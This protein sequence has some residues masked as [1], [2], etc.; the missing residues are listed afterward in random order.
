M[1]P[2]ADSSYYYNVYGGT[3][4]ET[5]T[6]EHFLNQ[7]SRHVDSLTFN[8]I[9]GKG[10][11]NMTAFQQEII[12]QVTC[13][14]ADFEYENSEILQSVLSSYNINGVSMSFGNS[15]TITTL[16]GVTIPK[17]L[18]AYLSQSGLCCRRF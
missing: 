11:E 9:V 10:F 8:R 7:S 13:K 4:L 16:N 14:L 1:T 18:Y 17:D 6:A 15:L 12:K 5:D 2:Y 3:V